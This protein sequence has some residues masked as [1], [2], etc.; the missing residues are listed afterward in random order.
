M[1]EIG[2]NYCYGLVSH[3]FSEEG[4]KCS[5][6]FSDLRK[7]MGKPGNPEFCCDRYAHCCVS[8]QVLSSSLLIFLIPLIP[9]SPMLPVF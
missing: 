8:L 7:T 6:K 9:P 4:K 3:S 5:K 1:E 2:F